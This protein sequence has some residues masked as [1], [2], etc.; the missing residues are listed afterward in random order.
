M[1]LLQNSVAGLIGL[2]AVASASPQVAK[3]DAQFNI[4]QPIDA[5]GKGAPILGEKHTANFPKSRFN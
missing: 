4:G 5:N 2:V 3:R 1:R